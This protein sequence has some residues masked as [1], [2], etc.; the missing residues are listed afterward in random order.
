MTRALFDLRTLL[1]ITSIGTNTQ[2][3]TQPSE[4]VIDTPS[5]VIQR[6]PTSTQAPWP[7]TIVLNSLD[8]N[9]PA[10]AKLSAG[11]FNGLDS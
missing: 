6:G 8:A 11:T 2:A 5:N 1:L 10:G 3:Q 9:K 7:Y 4:F